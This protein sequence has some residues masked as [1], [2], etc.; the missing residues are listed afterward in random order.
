[1]NLRIALVANSLV[2]AQSMGGGDR[3]LIELAKNWQKMGAD[4]TLFGPP[5]AKIVGQASGLKVLYVE[6][7][8]FNVNSLGTVGTYLRRIL[9]AISDQ[10]KFGTFDSIYSASE[11]LPDVVLSAKIKRQNPQASWV[12]GFYLR[13]PNPFAGEVAFNLRNL[14]QLFQQKISL[15]V[16]KLFKAAAVFVLGG[17]DEGNLRRRG[18]ERV[19]RIGGGVDL[20]FIDSIPNQSKIYEACFVGRLSQQKG[21]DDL[22][23]IW[24]RVVDQK[25]AAR[26]AFIGWGHPGQKEAFLGQIEQTGLKKNIEFLGFLDGAEKYKVV[27]SSKLLLFPSQYESFGIV[28]LEALA[29]GVPVIAYDLDVLKENFGEVVFLV[30]RGRIDVFAQKVLDLLNEGSEIMSLVDRGRRLAARFDWGQLGSDTFN[31]IRGLISDSRL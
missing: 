21:V 18:F 23:E 24:R 10:T 4:L 26:L 9:K 22:L 27:K 12:V 15:K 8:N 28:V 16:M 1:M 31:Y 5:E 7:S 20:N 17:D 2:S 11:S 29:A 14:L 19:L 6:T 25:P 13:A 3:I 30:P